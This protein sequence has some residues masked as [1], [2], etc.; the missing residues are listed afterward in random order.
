MYADDTTAYDIQSNMQTLQQNLQNALLLLNKWC[1]ENGMVINTDKTKVMLITS[2]QKRY[3]LQDNNLELNFND[4][5]LK[6][7]S[8]EKILGVQIEENL[9]WNSHFQYISRKKIASSLWLLSQ[10]KSFSS[11][12]DK[13]LFYN[14]YIRPHIEYCSVIWGNSTNL[15]IKKMTKLQR[16]ACK[17][18]LGSEYRHLDET[19]NHLNILSFNERVFLN[20]AKM[21]YKIANNIAPSYLINLFQMRKSSDDTISSLRSV[22]NINFLIPKPKLNLFK[23]SLSYSGAIIRNSIPLEIKNSNSLNMFVDKCK[24]WLKRG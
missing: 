8:N 2:R 12:D 3:N 18:I 17:L 20:K 15:N 13:L 9:L 22:T 24:A 14:A 19:S 4:V 7:S 10:I 11:V 6:L 16:R 23:N 21:M 5:D 1:R